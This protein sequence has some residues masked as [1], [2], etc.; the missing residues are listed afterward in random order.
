MLTMESTYHTGGTAIA[1]NIQGHSVFQCNTDQGPGGS[2]LGRD[3]AAGC[4]YVCGACPAHEPHDRVAQRRRDLWD[5]ATPHLGAICLKG[6]ISPPMGLVLDLPRAADQGQQP[7]RVGLLWCEA[8][9]AG[10]HCLADR[11]R[12]FDEDLALQ[13]Q[14]VG[15]SRPVTLPHPPGPGWQ[16]A[17]LATTMPAV[18]NCCRRTPLSRARR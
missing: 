18:Q 2:R 8:R 5:M 13:V 1:A 4:R 15:Q 12:V 14:H 7:R 11:P 3:T 17:L 9:N 16:P 6:H 10:P